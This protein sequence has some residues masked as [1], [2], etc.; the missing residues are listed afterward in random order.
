MGE[1]Q[2]AYIPVLVRDREEFDETKCDVK[3][4]G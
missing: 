2:H 3:R 4:V 1:Q